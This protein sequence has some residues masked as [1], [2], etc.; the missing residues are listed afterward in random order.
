[1]SQKYTLTLST[2]QAEVVA[3]AL[4]LYARIG[5]AQFE[6]ILSIFEGGRMGLGHVTPSDKLQAARQRIA[7]AKFTLTGYPENAGPGIMSP[8]VND[9]FRVAYD[10]KKV[11]QHKV[12]WTEKPEGGFGV[13][14]DDPHQTGKEPLAVVAT[15]IA[16]V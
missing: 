9:T 11:L 14:F 12:A 6:E 8:E 3:A 13:N 7:D 1:M 5:I 15:V 2:R 16:G 10:V 4:D